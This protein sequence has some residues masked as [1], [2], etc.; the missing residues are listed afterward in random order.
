MSLPGPWSWL[1]TRVAAS[2]VSTVMTMVV[3]VE[4]CPSM[5][6]AMCSAV[7]M[8]ALQMVKKSSQLSPCRSAQQHGW[9]DELEPK[10][11]R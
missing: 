2:L 5:D 10:K 1:L 7:E 11:M 3:V 4:W 8:G 6:L 9:K